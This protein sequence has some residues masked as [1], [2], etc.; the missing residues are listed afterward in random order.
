MALHPDVERVALLGWRLY[1]QSQYTK[2]ACIKRGSSLA[3]SDLDQ[4]ER[5]DYEF[6]QPNWRVVFSGSGIWGLD[7]DVPPLHKHDGVA[8]MAALVRVHGPLPPRPTVRTGSGGLTIFFRHTDERIIGEGGQP[9]P[10]MD[11]RRGLQSQT[12]PPSRHWSTKHLYQWIVPPWEVTPPPAPAWLLRMLEPPPPPPWSRPPIDTTDAAREKLVR[13]IRAVVGAQPGQRNNVLNRRAY[14]IG[15]YIAAGLVS[16]QEGV[17][18]LYGAARSIGLDH[19]EA[20]A[21]IKSGVRSGQRHG[22]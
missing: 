4:L 13:A 20:K 17:E 22:G 18:A 14:Q 21:T 7:L 9:M 16:E 6:R 2:A 11:P 15:R 1:P 12:I 5:W 19:I 8:A 10:G 3:T